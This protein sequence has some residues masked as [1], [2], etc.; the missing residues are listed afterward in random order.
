MRNG[1]ILTRA[2]R[3]PIAAAL[4][5]RRNSTCPKNVPHLPDRA[6]HLRVRPI[7][8]RTQMNEL[9]AELKTLLNT[10]ETD[11]QHVADGAAG[12]V[13][14]ALHAALTKLVA[15]FEAGASQGAPTDKEPTT[16]A[17]A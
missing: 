3:P 2:Q 7:F 8:E 6:V 14:S 4:F 5:A 1:F 17:E 16:Q 10:A 9:I 13:L 11:L 15:I 12:R